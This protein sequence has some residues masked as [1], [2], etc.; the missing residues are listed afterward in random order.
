MKE[1]EPA[2]LQGLGEGTLGMGTRVQGGPCVGAHGA[3]SW[4]AQLGWAV[5]RRHGTRSRGTSVDGAG[6]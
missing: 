6:F 1:Q 4:I 2:S 5:L 3:R